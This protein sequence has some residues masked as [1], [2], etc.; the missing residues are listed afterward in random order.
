MRY[1]NYVIGG[2]C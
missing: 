1:K 2:T